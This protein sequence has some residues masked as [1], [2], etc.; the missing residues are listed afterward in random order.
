[1]DSRR[2]GLRLFE[3]E[4]AFSTGL[5]ATAPCALAGVGGTIGLAATVAGARL[6]RTLLFGVTP[7]DPLVF[8]FTLIV[9]IGVVL[10]AAFVPA[11]RASAL[12]PMATL[13]TE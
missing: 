3:I 4:T 5:S 2:V 6:I 7:T 13:R 9:I 10:A 11:G 12:D 1:M 8:G